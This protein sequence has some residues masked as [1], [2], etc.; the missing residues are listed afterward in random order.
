MDGYILKKDS[1][2][3]GMERVKIY[4]RNGSPARTGRGL[5]AEALM[6]RLPLL[7]VEEEGRLS[8]PR[9]RDNFVERVFAYIEANNLKLVPM[10]S[11]VTAHLRRHP[12]WKRIVE[13][14]VEV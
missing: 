7:P 6:A 4:D 12:E 9:L 2:S 3:C 14:G 10:C 5:F 11:V 1:P 13:K 8:D